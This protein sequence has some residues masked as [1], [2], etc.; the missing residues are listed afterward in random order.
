MVF[1]LVSGV[2]LVEEENKFQSKSF[3]VLADAN[4]VQFNQ[5]VSLYDELPLSDE[6]IDKLVKDHTNTEFTFSFIGNKECAPILEGL[7]NLGLDN[8]SF[9]SEHIYYSPVYGKT[10]IFLRVVSN[11]QRAI[12]G[13]FDKDLI[14]ILH[15]KIF[16][17]VFFMTLFTFIINIILIFHL[18]KIF[19]TTKK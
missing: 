8:L 5:W 12:F 3:D 17:I 19:I 10:K 9:P 16:I 1:C 14:K 4:F 13:S 11:G 2:I 15:D 6:G 18:N 7:E